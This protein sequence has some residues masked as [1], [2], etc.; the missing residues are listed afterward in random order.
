[1]GKCLMLRLNDGCADTFPKYK[2]GYSAD[3]HS[4]ARSAASTRCLSIDR[5]RWTLGGWNPPAEG[6]P[7]GWPALPGYSAVH[8]FTATVKPGWSVV[9]VDGAAGTKLATAYAGP[10]GALT[11]IGLDTAGAQV[12]GFTEV[13]T[14]YAVGGL[15]PQATFQLAVWN[16]LG[17]GAIL[18]MP[19]VQTDAAGVATFDAPVNAVF[20]LTTLAPPQS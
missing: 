10:N 2:S 19:P 3:S 18:P 9:A 13:R 1:M 5:L 4:S 11:V 17:D 7:S 6:K 15:P 20:A 8:L 12:N 16:E 14:S